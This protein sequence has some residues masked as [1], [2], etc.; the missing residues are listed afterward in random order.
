M[1]EALTPQPQHSHFSLP[2]FLYSHQW[3]PTLICSSIHLRPAPKNIIRSPAC[4]G[5]GSFAF[6]LC[7]GPL[8]TTSDIPLARG[9]FHTWTES[10]HHTFILQSL[11]SQHSLNMGLGHLDSYMVPVTLRPTTLAAEQVAWWEPFLFPNLC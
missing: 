9:H 8:C 7:L 3:S 1:V 4:E 11:M 6:K 2:L 5:S 10:K